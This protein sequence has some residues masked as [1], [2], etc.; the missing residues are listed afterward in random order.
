MTSMGT[1]LRIT[2]AATTGAGPTSPPFLPFFLPPA[3]GSEEPQLA[4]KSAVQ[5]SVTNQIAAKKDFLD[6]KF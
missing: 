3:S 6:R 1:S 4:R 5:A 2:F